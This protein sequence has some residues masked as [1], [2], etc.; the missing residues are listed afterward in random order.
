MELST[1]CDAPRWLET[2]LCNACQEHADFYD[3]EE[4][5]YI[6]INKGEE[7][8]E[9]GSAA[10]KDFE[11]HMIYC[12]GCPLCVQD[13]LKPID[14]LTEVWNNIYDDVMEQSQ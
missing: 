8:P 4:D 11:E 9:C 13:T 6:R 3:E 2:D 7:C 10:T 5:K 14:K 1:C 12:T